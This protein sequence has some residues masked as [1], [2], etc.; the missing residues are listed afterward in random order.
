MTGR[1][2]CKN[3]MMLPVV[4]CQE[5]NSQH[6]LHKRSSLQ[7]NSGFEFVQ[8]VG[9]L[10][11]CC[12]P[13][14]IFKLGMRNFKHSATCRSLKGSYKRLNNDTNHLAALHQSRRPIS[15]RNEELHEYLKIQICATRCHYCGH[16]E[17]TARRKW[18]R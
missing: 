3:L 18:S 17:G 12:S 9:C 6:S 14:S 4:W 2:K 10:G 5:A 15:N 11:H 1:I 13:P 8:S 7:F 16:D